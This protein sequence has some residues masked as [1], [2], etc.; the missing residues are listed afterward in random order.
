MQEESVVFSLNGVRHSRL[1][2]RKELR[3]GRAVY[4]VETSG[5]PTFSLTA[6]AEA[7]AYYVDWI[8]PSEW[9]V[10]LVPART[11]SPEEVN[12]LL[13]AVEGRVTRDAIERAAAMSLR[14]MDPHLMYKTQ[15]FHDTA[16]ARLLRVAS[17][18]KLCDSLSDV[19]VGRALHGQWAP[20]V[21]YHLL[22]C[23]DLLGQPDHWVT[24]QDWLRSKRSE[25]AL[26][27]E[28]ALRDAPAGPV[29]LSLHLA[30]VHGRH[31]GAKRSFVRF[32][33]TVLPKPAR[34]ALLESLRISRLSNPPSIVELADAVDE[35]KDDYFY[36]L[37]NA[38][39]HDAKALAGAHPELFPMAS[40]D[41]WVVRAQWVEH[42][43][44]V[45]VCTFGWPNALRDAVIA[46][47]A[48]RLTELA[49][50]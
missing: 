22:T 31:F 50:N 47:I 9:Y 32:L 4:V 7:Q 27:R 34:E 38:Y 43:H 46:G 41:R 26:Q 40:G 17:R 48:S 44:W 30:E 8:A 6:D 20:T 16:W 45:H 18:L 24:F 37:R 13:K 19:D 11:A 3:P 12:V 10:V 29:A 21:E 25:H 42:A 49:G 14:A 2:A 39:T 23:F 5:G 28:E 33:R 1:F 36:E 15:E 35:E